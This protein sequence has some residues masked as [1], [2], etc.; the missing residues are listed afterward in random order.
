MKKKNRLW[1]INFIVLNVTT[2][3]LL[4]HIWET[5]QENSRASS[6]DFERKQWDIKRNTQYTPQARFEPNNCPSCQAVLIN[7]LNWPHNTF[8]G[9][10]QVILIWAKLEIKHAGQSNINYILN[11]LITDFKSG[12]TERCCYG[13]RCERQIILG[14]LWVIMAWVVINRLI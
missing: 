1:K 13:K 8:C 3:V 4:W 12:P 11:L 10:C 14:H 6:Q 2:L 7:W 9:A 5:T